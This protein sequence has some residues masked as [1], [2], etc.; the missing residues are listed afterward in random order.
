MVVAYDGGGGGNR[1]N[2]VSV[3]IN[4]AVVAVVAVVV[5]VTLGMCG[6]FNK[7]QR[8]FPA[9]KVDCARSDGQIKRR[10]IYA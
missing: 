9:Q 3:S 6:G 10:I 2:A 7:S 8:L 1:S 5:F 4:G